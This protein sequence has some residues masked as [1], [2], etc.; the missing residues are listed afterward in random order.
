MQVPL[1]VSFRNVTVSE[2]LES[3][4]RQRVEKRDNICT[5]INCCRVVL[6][7]PTNTNTRPDQPDHSKEPD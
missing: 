1:Q 3:Y 5:T 2:T 6:E 7:A 4:I